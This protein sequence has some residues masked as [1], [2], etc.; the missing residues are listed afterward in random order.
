MTAA[1]LSAPPAQ[2][3][4]A[5]VEQARTQRNSAPAQGALAAREAAALA[6]EL[7]PPE[8]QLWRAKAL[9]QLSV[10]Q[11]NGTELVAAAQ[12]AQEAAALFAALPEPPPRDHA[13][14]LVHHGIALTM[15]GRTGDALALFEAARDISHAAGD[16]AGEANAL[17][18]IAVV[19]NMLGDDDKAVAL[20][21]QL[22]PIYERL[23]D[24]YHRASALNNMAYAQVCWG[25]RQAAA[26]D[27]AAAREQFR[28]A[29]AGAEAALPLAE[30]TDHPDFVV[31]CLDTLSAALRELGD[32]E[33][34]QQ[35]LARQL[36]LTRQLAGR[37]MEAVTLGNWGEVQR[38]AG[39]SAAALATL[40]QADELFGETQLAE[41]H[42]TTLLSLVDTYEALGR[43]A[44]ALATH[45]RYHALQQRL[46]AD[47]AQ[48]KLQTLE[49]RLQLERSEAE[50]ALSRQR[51]EELAA[52]ND[53]L[54]AADA[55]REALVQ[56]LRRHSTEDPLTGLANRRAFDSRLALEV[57]RARRYRRP[58]SL[59]LLDVDLFKQINDQGSHAVGDQVLR[60]IAELLRRHTR[61]TD[62]AARLGGDELVLLLPDTELADA[63]TL[64]RKLGQQM[65]RVDW[66]QW[67]PLLQPTLSVGV[68][69][70]DTQAGLAAAEPLLSAADAQLYR[71]KA[72]GR[73]RICSAT[74]QWPFWAFAP[75]ASRS[76]PASG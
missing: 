40:Q 75:Q 34:A 12:A 62:L 23:G 76:G 74:A 29:V 4:A 27:T 16:A 71:A 67:L 39:Q 54:L 53:R 66:H 55:E 45:R 5:L 17:L 42:A 60:S 61:P 7:A 63:V 24:D 47:A 59:A 14:A 31:S 35:T 11:R 36:V 26:G 22:L 44:E 43:L 69:S 21:R 30:A 68:A 20:Y 2:Q 48:Q 57:E 3:V 10:C 51:S 72:L 13:D 56:E 37:R 33:R 52:L 38:R 9:S 1:G 49:S 46:R 41:E 28:A 65:S 19:A 25:M 15:L 50:L 64:C 32:F 73:N 6:R 58:L 8:A 18:D 70:L